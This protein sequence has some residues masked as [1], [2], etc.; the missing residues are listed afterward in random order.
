MGCRDAGEDSLQQRP[1]F[2]FGHPRSAVPRVPQQAEEDVVGA[3]RVVVMME[4][5]T[6]D[7]RPKILKEC[8]LPITGRRCVSAICTDRAW[9]DVTNEGLRLREIAPGETFQGVQDL[10]EPRLQVGPDVKPMQL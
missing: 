5:A 6:R 9:I 7:G 8:T 3:K 10:T 1:G 2:R 4:H